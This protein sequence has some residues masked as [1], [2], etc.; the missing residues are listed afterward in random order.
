MDLTIKGNPGTGNKYNDVRVGQTGSYNPAAKDVHH[1]YLA[2]EPAES[3][4]SAWFRKLAEEFRNDERLRRK[5]DD[6]KRY[7]TVLD[8]TRGLDRKLEDG[9]FAPDSIATARRKK[10]Y[11]VKKATKYQYYESAQRIDSYLYAKVC[12][13]FDSYVFP[14]IR[15]QHPLD[16]VRTAVYEQV[17]IPILPEIHEQRSADTCLRYTEDDI[18]GILYYFSGNCHINW[19]VYDLH[20]GI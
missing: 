11:Y 7:K 17:V 1:Y 3:R 2:P 5:L 20:S 18:F 12:N 6:I 14:L 19:T 4:L 13:R 16:E 15:G 10:Q 8:K 9:G